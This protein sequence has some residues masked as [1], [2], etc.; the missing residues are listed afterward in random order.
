MHLKSLGH[1]ILNDTLYGGKF[2]GNGLLRF[3]FPHLFEKND[4]DDK[5]PEESHEESTKNE[6]K[7]LNTA[8]EKDDDLANHDKNDKDLD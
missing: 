1:P 7:E 8:K 4:T 3:K 2:V 6:L 5:K